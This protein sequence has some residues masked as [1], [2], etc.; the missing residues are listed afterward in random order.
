MIEVIAP[1]IAFAFSLM[2]SI[3]SPNEPRSAA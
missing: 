1:A 3:V 2:K